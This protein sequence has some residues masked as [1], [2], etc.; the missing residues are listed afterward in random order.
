MSVGDGRDR[1][2]GQSRLTPTNTLQLSRCG[3]NLGYV[4]LKKRLNAQFL[5]FISKNYKKNDKIE[6]NIEKCAV[7]QPVNNFFIYILKLI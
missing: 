3:S 4:H 5:C 6:S 7:S 1:P 2:A